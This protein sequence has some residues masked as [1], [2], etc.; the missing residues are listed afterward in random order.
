[1]LICFLLLVNNF[2]SYLHSFY[3][4]LRFFNRLVRLFYQWNFFN[5]NMLALG[6]VEDSVI[7][8]KSSFNGLS[9][10]FILFVNPF[11]DDNDMRLFTFDNCAAK[12]LLML[13]G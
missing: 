2:R 4:L 1:M 8:E 12:I 3:N 7:A 6:D 5:W 10:F 11:P 9:G 13:E